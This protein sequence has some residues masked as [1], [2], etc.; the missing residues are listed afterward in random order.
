MAPE[1]ALGQAYEHSV[2]LW[3]LG[4]LLYCMAFAQYPFSPAT[5]HEELVIVQEKQKPL[6]F[7]HTD[8]EVQNL[9]DG[10]LQFEGQYRIFALNENFEKNVLSF[11]DTVT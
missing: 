5:S 2:D 1:V 9:L 4:V 8:E 7:Q 3:S 6:E 11:L 10:L